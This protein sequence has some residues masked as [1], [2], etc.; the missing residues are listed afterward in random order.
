MATNYTVKVRPKDNIE[1]VI[2]RFIKKT[3]K[4]GII[5]EAKERRYYTKPSDKKRRQ[6]QLVERRRKKDLEKRKK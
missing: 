4:L 1:R 5:D 2:K 6:K 3:K